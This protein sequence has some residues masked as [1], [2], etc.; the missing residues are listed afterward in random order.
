I[1]EIDTF[2]DQ[3]QG[4]VATRAGGALA[5]RHRDGESGLSGLTEVSGEISLSGVPLE[6][7]RV[8][9]K[10]MPVFLNAGA[11]SGSARGRFG[12]GPL[13]NGADELDEALSGV[14]PL[15]D[16]VTQS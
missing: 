4:E 2:L 16:G 8:E 9:L 7:G 1:E 10:A 13:V 12:S 5:I 11:V 15:L 3:L 6:S 14:Q